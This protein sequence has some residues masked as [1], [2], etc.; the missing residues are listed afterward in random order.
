MGGPDIFI[1]LFMGFVYGLAMSLVLTF[2]LS[3]TLFRK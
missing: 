2:A 3:Y 1:R